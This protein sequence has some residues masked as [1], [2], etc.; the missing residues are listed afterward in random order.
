MSRI[1]EIKR[2]IKIRYMTPEM[3]VEELEKRWMETLSG[4]KFYPLEAKV[5]KFSIKD[6]AHA[7][8]NICRWGGHTAYHFSVAQHCCIMSSLVNKEYAL[9]ALMHDATEAYLGDIPTPIKTLFPEYLD[10]EEKLAKKLAIKYKYNYP[11]S[12]QVYRV[13]SL[14]KKIE[15]EVRDEIRLVPLTSIKVI[16]D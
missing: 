6:I 8:S 13:D 11:Y 3:P 16:Y 14:M 5:D 4:I 7:L 12:P 10:I 15:Y 9:E 2:K 1:S